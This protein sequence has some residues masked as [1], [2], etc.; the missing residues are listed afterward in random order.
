MGPFVLQTGS[1]EGKRLLGVRSWTTSLAHST[2]IAAKA[3]Q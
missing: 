2:A 3:S 1:R